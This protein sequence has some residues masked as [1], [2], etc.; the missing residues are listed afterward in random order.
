MS[1]ATMAPIREVLAFEAE[2]GRFASLYE[3]MTLCWELGERAFSALQ[4][5]AVTG[6][7]AATGGAA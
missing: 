5:P 3:D 7:Q 6:L 2:K 4:T 1:T